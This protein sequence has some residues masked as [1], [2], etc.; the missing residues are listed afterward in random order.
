MLLFR[1]ITIEYVYLGISINMDTYRHINYS[2]TT[3]ALFKSRTKCE[4]LPR[5]V[6]LL[7]TP[8][9]LSFEK[10]WIGASYQ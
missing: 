3:N 10:C 9:G 8:R 1:I 7:E 5:R 4:I 6:T 2:T